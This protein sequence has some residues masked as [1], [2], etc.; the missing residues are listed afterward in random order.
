MTQR[1]LQ[2]F[3]SERKRGEKTR[4]GFTIVEIILAVGLFTLIV[5]GAVGA[6][7]EAFQ[8]NRLGEEESLANTRASEGLE[9]ARA[10]ATHDYFDLENGSHGLTTQNGVWEFSGSQEVLGKYTRKVIVSNVYRDLARN[11]VP[12]GG[13]LDLY[14]KRVE[15]LVSW[16]F[17]P[18]RTTSISLKTYFTYWQGSF[19][20]WSTAKQ[21]GGLN[22]PGIGDAT[23]IDVVNGKGYV[24]TMKNP[25]GEFFT[26]DL[27]DPLRPSILA[28]LRIGDHVNGV[29][30][31]NGYAYLA[32]SSSTAELIVV[33]VHDPSNPTRIASF[34]ITSVTQAND[35]AV[36]GKY[37][38]VGTQN[39]TTAGE[40]YIFD[41][42]NPAVPSLV[43]NFEVGDHVY[44]IFVRKGKAYLANAN[45]HKELI[46]VDVSN[47]TSPVE[48]GSYDAPLAGAP[49]Q[50]VFAGGG[51]VHLATRNNTGSPPEYYLLDASDPANITQIGSLDIGGRTNGVEAGANFAILAT[52]TPNQELMLIDTTDP[53]GP[54][55]IFSLP[56]GSPAFGVALRGCY[57]YFASGDDNQEVKV[58]A[59]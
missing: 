4:R 59:P 39:S 26:L 11:I 46:I 58:V 36:S 30:V 8:V 38:Y 19:C 28:M 35:I 48:A 51:I 53:S 24:T 57:A 20:N 12:T 2:V 14:T 15:S 54:K 16:D 5:G 29:A 23:D 33:D 47:P 34:D 44:G 55:K 52:E 50:A 7:V 10:I 6:V 3:I 31:S 43:S 13:K 56:L 32:T 49:G 42:S 9:A 18:A 1:L 22:L 40:L 27:T 41:V 25:P 17:T 21:I 45:V 37:V